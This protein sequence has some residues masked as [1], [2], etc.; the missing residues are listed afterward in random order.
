MSNRFLSRRSKSVAIMLVLGYW[1]FAFGCKHGKCE[2]GPT[3]SAGTQRS[4]N[5]GENCQS[6]HLPDGEGEVCWSV[7]GTLYDAGGSHP[8]T[9]AHALLFGSPLGQGGLQLKLDNDD[10]GN[11]YTSEDVTFGSGLFPAV[12]SA[13][14]DTSFM[15]EPIRNGACNSCHGQSTA[16]ITVP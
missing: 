16:G 11:I 9:H 13:A 14:G 10:L 12:I 15:M 4:H 2:T 5:V 8:V 3:S 7:A 1:T 6:C